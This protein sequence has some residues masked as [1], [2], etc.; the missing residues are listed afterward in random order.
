MTRILIAYFAEKGEVMYDGISNSLLESGNDV[1]RI[2][3][4]NQTAGLKNGNIAFSHVRILKKIEKFNPEV[5]LSYNNCL[6]INAIEIIKGDICIL[7]A[8]NPEYFWNKQYLVENKERFKYLGYQ[9]CSKKLYKN[10]FQLELNDSNYLYFPAATTIKSKNIKQDKNIS[11]IGTNFAPKSIKDIKL[12]YSKAALD[13]YKNIKTNY[14]YNT[15]NLYSN[16][17]NQISKNSFCELIKLVKTYYTGQDRIQKLS[18]LTDLGLTIFGVRWNSKSVF[19]NL[20]VASCFDEKSIKSKEDNEWVYNSSKISVNISH[21]QASTSFSW[22]VM[23]IM[24]SN[25]CLVME[26]KKDWHDLFDKYISKEVQNAIIYSDEFDMR[27]KCIR[28][29]R[30]E[31]LRKKCVAECQKAIQLNGLWKCRF[32]ALERFLSVNLLNNKIRKPHTTKYIH[33]YKNNNKRKILNKRNLVNKLKLKKRFKL[34]FYSIALFI[35]QI[36]LIDRI[37]LPRFVRD[38]IHTKINEYKR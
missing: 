17:K 31:E 24:A 23:D 2:N 8:D 38:K 7:D 15:E 30:D 26:D 5:V 34:I 35:S 19:F 9:E 10:A 3:I 33:I 21:P 14:Y 37:F 18:M 16:Y 12:F 27:Q 4:K 25:S 1:M 22:R 20:D 32:E 36:L 6:P 29:L 28:L 13:I 11:F